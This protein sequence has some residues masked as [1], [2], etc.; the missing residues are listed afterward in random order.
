MIE[1]T[2]YGPYSVDCTLS[3]FRRLYADSRDNS[4]PFACIHA[5]WDF[6]ICLLLSRPVYMQ[7]FPGRS[8]IEEMTDGKLK[9]EIAV[10]FHAANIGRT[11]VLQVSSPLI[12][13]FCI[14]SMQAMLD[15]NLNDIISL[16][17]RTP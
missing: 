7:K 4:T 14:L 3:V 6:V 17:I 10:L 2:V 15:H 5:C 12:H 8:I 1:S 16:M 11:D 9:E 13:F